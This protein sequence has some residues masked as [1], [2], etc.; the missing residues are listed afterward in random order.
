MTPE[1]ARRLKKLDLSGRKFA[2]LAGVSNTAVQEWGKKRKEPAWVDTR[3]SGWE[4]SPTAL[5]E[6]L[7]AL[8]WAIESTS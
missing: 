6:A 8:R 3:I 1:T 2:R 7:D 5:Q 4:R